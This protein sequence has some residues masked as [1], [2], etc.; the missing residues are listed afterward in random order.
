MT[1]NNS[2]ASSPNKANIQ[3]RLAFLASIMFALEVDCMGFDMRV[4]QI[5]SL[6]VE[7]ASLKTIEVST[8]EVSTMESTLEALKNKLILTRQVMLIRQLAIAYQFRAAQ[9]LKIGRVGRQY[10]M[11]HA[12]IIESAHDSKPLWSRPVL[13][14][15]EMEFC[16]RLEPVFHNGLSWTTAIDQLV[17]EIRQLAPSNNNDITKIL[18]HD[19]TDNQLKERV[20]S[21]E[22]VKECLQQTLNANLITNDIFEDASVLLEVLNTLY[23]KSGNAGVLL[24][25][26]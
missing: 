11:T 16:S 3:H 18:F 6:L 20:A 4:A 26:K 8:T 2:L 9:S 5:N 10:Y 22:D 7:I 14:D 17:N 15:I 21:Y 23:V 24:A 25:H 13:I 19:P 1:D 12:E